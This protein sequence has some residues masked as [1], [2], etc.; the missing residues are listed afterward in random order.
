MCLACKDCVSLSDTISTCQ[1]SHSVLLEKMVHCNDMPNIKPF[2]MCHASNSSHRK[3]K[4]GNNKSLHGQR[5]RTQETS[6]CQILVGT[7][8]WCNAG[9]LRC[10]CLCGEKCSKQSM[11]KLLMTAKDV[12]SYCA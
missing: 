6:T 3:D 12:L 10:R 4:I 8:P 2:N 9:A 1:A 5:E 11:H 7:S